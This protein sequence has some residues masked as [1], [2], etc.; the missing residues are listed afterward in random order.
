MLRSGAV[1]VA[2]MPRRDDIADIAQQE[3]F[4]DPLVLVCAR[5]DPLAGK[6]RFGWPDI[7][8]KPMIVR[9]PASSVRQWLEAEYLKR[10]AVLRPAFEV[11]QAATAVGLISAGLGIGVM[12][13]SLL[14]SLNAEGLVIRRFAAAADAAWAICLCRVVG[15]DASPAA[16]YFGDACRRDFGA[17]PS[18]KARR[19]RAPMLP[20]QGS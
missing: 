8:G 14:A 3:L 16:R 10:G 5:T 18:T 19:G 2:L 1:D 11:Q 6:R 7:L 15:R 12:P 9:G 17:G 13:K 20:A 4:R